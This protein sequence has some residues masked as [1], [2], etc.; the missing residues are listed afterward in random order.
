MMNHQD[1]INFLANLEAGDTVTYVNRGMTGTI[2]AKHTITVDRVTDSSIFVGTN[3]YMKSSGKLIGS[4]SKFP[5]PA[6]KEEIQ[7]ADKYKIIQK[8]KNSD[9]TKLSHEQLTL[10][11]EILDTL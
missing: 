6:T 3:R 4:N 8:I 1:Y 2:Q 10:I 5:R 11:G 7:A 9:F